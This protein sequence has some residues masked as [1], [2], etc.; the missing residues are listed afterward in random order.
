MT[1]DVCAKNLLPAVCWR[2]DECC[3]LKHQVTILHDGETIALHVLLK[4]IRED[5]KLT[6]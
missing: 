3:A 6:V 2:K 1:F 4:G 5:L